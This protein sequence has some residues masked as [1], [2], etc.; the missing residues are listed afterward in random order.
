MRMPRNDLGGDDYYDG[1]PGARRSSTVHGPRPPRTG[2]SPAWRRRSSSRRCWASFSVIGGLSPWRLWAA[3]AFLTCAARTG[4]V[5]NA[6]LRLDVSAAGVID[7][8][9]QLRDGVSLRSTGPPRS[10]PPRASR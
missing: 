1:P 5:A 7:P 6:R 4:R 10:C 2:S 9:K 3:R 8:T